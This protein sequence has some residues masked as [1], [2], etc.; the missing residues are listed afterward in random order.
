MYR[1]RV[2]KK[3]QKSN[4][5][6]EVQMSKKETK[7]GVG[8]R[9]FLKGAA[10]AAGAV[11]LA[12]LGAKEVK[13]EPKPWLP[14]KWGKEADVVV[15]G[16]GAAGL[17]AAL[18]AA[19]R[20]AS[21][22]LIDQH[23][24][25]GGSGIISWGGTGLG[26]GTRVQKQLGIEDSADLI[27][28][29]LTDSKYELE[30]K[31]NDRAVVRAFADNSAGTMKWL[32]E[33]GVKFLDDVISRC[34]YNWGWSAR[35]YH[36]SSWDEQGTAR[37]PG[38]LFSM[39]SKGKHS[40][41]GIFRPLETAVRGKGV[42]ILVEHKVTR[43]VREEP[44]KG[45]V[46]GIEVEN[47]GKKLYLRA[48]KGVII[49]T[50]GSKGNVQLRRA[51][52]PR[53]T[54]EYQATGEPWV[55][56]TGDGIIAAQEIGAQLSSDRGLDSHWLM[57]RNLIGC[58]YVGLFSVAF[59]PGS[60]VYALQRSEGISVKDWQDCILVKKSGLR[61]HDE[62]AGLE[63]GL[64][65]GKGEEGIPFTDAAMADGGGPIWAI[66]DSDAAKRENWVLAPPN[67]DSQYFFSGDTIAEL[68]GKIVPQISASTL[69]D[70]VSK[71]NSYVDAGKDPD[72][73]KPTP[74]YKIQSPPFYAAWATPI[75]H[76]TRAGLR[77]NGRC[78][79]IDIYGEVIPGL[80]AGGE[81]AGGMN[82][83]GI[84]RAIVQGRIA[85]RDAAA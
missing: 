7:K 80:Y 53:L 19:E 82:V 67:V 23:F 44:L 61:F 33:H 35:R 68:A 13:A 56:Q 73:G 77:I 9:D 18:E 39:S 41:A 15:A 83:F 76:D 25:V 29:D 59:L 50:G 48:K 3:E 20:G 42:L 45:R 66:F 34:Q 17:P 47:K 79:V 60:P 55:F 16:A 11:G 74:K 36:F 54:E 70:T 46:L 85:G 21:V 26:G 22:I 27:F 57:K 8:R 71:Y 65:G 69:Q 64:Q 51:F 14:A 75:L 40:G 12:G 30:F 62:T 6:E 63:K 52:D 38:R 28:K 4:R 43:I 84:G 1:C 72:F 81:S 10:V 78:Q 31:K 2:K 58:R 5:K 49:A 32:E 24:D 37:S